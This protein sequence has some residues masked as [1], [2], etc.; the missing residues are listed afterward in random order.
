MVQ[1]R[2]SGGAVVLAGVPEGPTSLAVEALVR[3]DPAWLAQRELDERRVLSLPP[4]V[5]VARLVGS[6]RALDEAVSAI[7]QSVD[8]DVLGPL[9]IP[10]H[11]SGE[12]A[13]HQTIVRVPLARGAA[14]AASL[15]A[16][17]STRSARKDPEPLNIQVDSV[18]DA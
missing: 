1:P 8:V 12:P 15:A 16:V 5:R 4:A 17:R 9:P 7:R 14:L 2:S 18:G 6:R 13:K 10:D 11:G 3:W